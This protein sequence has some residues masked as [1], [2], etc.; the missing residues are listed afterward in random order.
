MTPT[1]T[2]A[3]WEDRYARG[4][5]SGRGSYGKFAQFK[6]DVINGFLKEFP[7]DSAIE[8]GCGDG[9]QLV[10]LEYPQYLGLDVSESAVALCRD[11]FKDDS[12]KSFRA[13]DALDTPAVPPEWV[14]DLALSLDVLY[15][16]VEQEVFEKYLALLFESAREYVI[17]FS[18][19]HAQRRFY[20]APHVYHRPFSTV[21]A[22][23]QPDWELFRTIHHP[24]GRIRRLL[25]N[26]YPD[27]YFYR[28]RGTD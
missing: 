5:T 22:K 11:R 14:S 28:R 12:T 16:L 1:N 27:F 15:H 10:Q 21:V 9:S 7:V 18:T 24:M 3:Y 8:F 17:V 19:D 23:T 13:Y 2:N 26:P 6:R 20:T 25:G 4:G